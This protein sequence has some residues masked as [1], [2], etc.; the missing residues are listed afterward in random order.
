[1][2]RSVN[3]GKEIIYWIDV[4]DEPEERYQSKETGSG[5]TKRPCG[6]HYRILRLN[7]ECMKERSN[8]MPY[9]LAVL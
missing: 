6:K 8:G 5:T 3:T 9:I 1:M 7:N 4:K 2:Y